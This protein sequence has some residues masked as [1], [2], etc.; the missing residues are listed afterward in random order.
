MGSQAVESILRRLSRAAT[1]NCLTKTRPFLTPLLLSNPF[2]SS[3]SCPSLLLQTPPPISSDFINL[4]PKHVI[5]TFK[6]WFKSRQKPLIERIFQIFSSWDD[7]DPSS[8]EAA[9]LA[10]AQLGIRLSEAFVLEVLRYKD[11]VLCCLK[12]FDWAG[13]QHGFCHTRSTFQ[14]IFK[15]LSRAKLMS[16]MLDF[17]DNYM[18]QR[19]FHRVRFSDTLVMGYAIAGKPFVALQL[20]GRMRYQG[21]DLDPFAYNVLLNA[22]V[23]ASC[24]DGAEVVLSQIRTRGYENEVTKTVVMKSLCKRMWLEEAEKFLRGLVGKGEGANGHI[25]GVLV[26]ALCKQK[27]FAHGG[28]LIQEFSEMGCVPMVRAYGVWIRHLVQAGKLD[29]A[30]EFLQSKKSLEGYVPEVFR[31]NILI[32]KLLRE[33]R[34]Q[35]VYD[36]LTEMNEYQIVPD[37]Y[38][39]NN[40]LCFFCKVGMVDVAIELFKSRSEYGLTPSSMAYN[41]F[42]NT[43]CGDGSIEEACHILKNA[44]D[45]GYFP[46]KRTFSILSDALCREGKLDKMKDLVIIALE[47]NFMPSNSTYDKF[48]AA[49]CRAQR[50]EDGYLIH[51][52]LNRLHK[53][54][55]PSTYASMIYGF[56]NFRRGDIAARL[57]LEM[58]EK[59]HI[60]ARHLFRDVIRCLCDM[61]DPRKQVLQLLELQLSY[62]QPSTMIF[63]YYIDGAG[64]A[65][66]PDLAREIYERMLSSGIVPNLSS[67]ILML[68]S[69][70]KSERISDAVNFFH[71]VGHRREN[72]RKMYNTMVVGLCKVNRSDIALSVLADIRKKGLF[73]SLQVYE[74]LIRLLAA[75]NKHEVV[76]MLINDL[77]A[78]GRHVSPFIGNV[79]LYR[80]LKGTGLYKAWLRT[81]D[82]IQETRSS[83]MLGQMLAA[84]SAHIKTSSHVKDLE[85][86]IQECFPPNIY[87]YNMLLRKLCVDQ[88]DEALKLFKDIRQK[89]YEPNQWTYDIL[90]HGLVKHGRNAEARRWMDE[91]LHQGFYLTEGTSLII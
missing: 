41:Y 77:D 23:E 68:Q 87:S 46:G 72:R 7:D 29:S 1:L 67:D 26:D 54:L 12:F 28:R 70:L 13:R 74:E 15:I 34:V 51:G 83:S 81:R 40:A 78:V 49:L 61:D 35:E 62:H 59:G 76:M 32:S 45:Q 91:M 53:V 18:Q 64:H 52:E 44:V 69:Y 30:L 58:Q 43:L 39:M 17:L 20:F 25:L 50:V 31:Y 85:L 65:K 24:F 16:L 66:I 86:V 79:L 38:T 14:A 2:S 22:L 8:I 63:N 75:E 56:I 60:P 6:D 57:L 89:G 84:F 11:D 55:R 5:S 3:A 4:E 37:T 48:I 71:E 82:A 10:L 33:N 21:Q 42:I 36:M 80:S 9:N 47:R 27:N 73:P 90:V 19:N 88:I